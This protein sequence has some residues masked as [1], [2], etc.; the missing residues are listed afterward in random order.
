MWL[1]MVFYTFFL[2]SA[3]YHDSISE[4]FFSC[5]KEICWVRSWQRSQQQRRQFQDRGCYSWAQ[6]P[7]E[8]H[9][10]DVSPWDVQDVG[11]FQWTFRKSLRVRLRRWMLL[12][13]EDSEG[14]SC[15]APHRETSGEFNEFLSREC[16]VLRHLPLFQHG[17]RPRLF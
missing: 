11:N 5:I 6:S 16:E 12:K 10:P 9:I 2:G 17:L 13:G 14:H 3:E 1:E 15:I 8:W 4:T 7:P